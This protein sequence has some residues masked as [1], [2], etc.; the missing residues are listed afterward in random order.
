MDYSKYFPQA[1][2]LAPPAY[3][4]EFSSIQAIIFHRNIGSDR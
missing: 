1:L 4:P 2:T 3:S